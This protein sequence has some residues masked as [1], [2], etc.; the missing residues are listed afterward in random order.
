MTLLPDRVLAEIWAFV[1]GDMDVQAFERWVYENTDKLS[2]CLEPRDFQVVLSADY[3]SPEDVRGVR[4][5]FRDY[6]M[7]SSSLPC[8]CVT[9]S[10]HAVVDMGEESDQ[11]LASVERRYTRGEPLWW[12]WAGECTRCGQWWL[13]AQEERHNDVFCLRRMSSSEG[14]DLAQGVWP[15]DFDTYESLLRLGKEAG[16][17]VDFVDPE[18]AKSLRWTIADLANAR[19]GIRS[20]ELASLLNLDPDLA[21]ALSERAIREDKVEI[22]IDDE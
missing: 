20:S 12:L 16:R 10:S 18:S 7:L 4:D 1:R 3:R 19:P 14:Q 11:C 9:L 22:L 15:P 17:R 21:A 2:G 6:A 5:K 8:R 13:V